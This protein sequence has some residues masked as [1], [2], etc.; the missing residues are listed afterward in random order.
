[1]TTMILLMY[2]E[3]KNQLHEFLDNFYNEYVLI[4]RVDSDE[5]CFCRK[6]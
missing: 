3:L 1:M 4:N 5:S 6:N 2:L